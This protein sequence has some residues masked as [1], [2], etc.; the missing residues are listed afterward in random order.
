MPLIER[1]VPSCT[2]SPGSFFASGIGKAFLVIVA[3]LPAM[4]LLADIQ[5]FA[6]NVPFMDDWQFVPL[7]ER[8]MNGTLTFQELWAPHDEH[9]LLLPRMIIIAS[10][11][12]SHGDYGV[13]CFITFAVVAII[14]A[15]L[16]WL[17]VRLN[18]Y[19]SSVLCTWALANIALFSPIQFHNWLCRCNLPTSYP[20]PSSRFAFARF[21]LEYL[22]C[23]N[24]CWQ[25]SLRLLAISVSCKAT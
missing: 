23:P 12:A 21:M 19:K 16:L 17:M 4:A 13:Q 8:A 25:P 5:R 3:F 1:N 9:R 10:M 22:H 11:F 20:M 24:S 18:G 15:C 2:G 7:L 6:V 14:S